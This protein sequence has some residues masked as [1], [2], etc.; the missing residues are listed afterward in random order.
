[1][2]LD[3][4]KPKAE[5]IAEAFRGLEALPAVARTRCCGMIGALDLAGDEGYLAQAGWRIYDE[6]RRRGAYLR[7]MG[8]VVYVAPPLNIDDDALG[9]LL[10]IVADSIEA[11]S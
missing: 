1:G 6:A 11:V 8:N 3:R 2:I 9:E 10:G 7:P 4:A 5:R